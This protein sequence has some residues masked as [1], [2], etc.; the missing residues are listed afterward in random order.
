VE[1]K[2]LKLE[3]IGYGGFR[4]TQLNRSGPW[5]LGIGL[6]MMVAS[7]VGLVFQWQQFHFDGNASGITRVFDVLFSGVPFM[8]TLIAFL[9]GLGM[10]FGGR[11]AWGRRKIFEFG[12]SSLELTTQWRSSRKTKRFDRGDFAHVERSQSGH[13][14]HSVIR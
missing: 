5:L 14:N 9:I 10:M 8:M 3:P 13:V 11:W 6:V 2:G 1:T 12:K 7:G 4:V